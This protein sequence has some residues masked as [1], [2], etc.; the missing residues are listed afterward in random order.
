MWF[1]IIFIL[2]SANISKK[3]TTKTAHQQ[4]G[5]T[6]YALLCSLCIANACYQLHK[7]THQVLKLFR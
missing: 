1:Y 2:S 5:E 3:T 4:E 7:D 6:Q